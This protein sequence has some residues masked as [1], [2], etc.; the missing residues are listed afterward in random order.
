MLEKV[1]KG[2]SEWRRL[3]TPEQYRVTREKGTER[4]S[5][6]RFHD[7]NGT[8]VYLCVCCGSRLFSSREKYAAPGKWPAFWAPIAPRNVRAR[9]EVFHFMIR[10]EVLCSRCDAHL[11][12]LFSD[13]Q[14]PSRDRYV[15]NSAALS[16]KEN[17]LRAKRPEADMHFPPVLSPAYSGVY[18][19]V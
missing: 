1:I 14:S 12:Y 5:S 10:N 4:A 15:I 19:P 6:G 3:L 9:R 7:F 11:G 18:G 16:F 8:G 2:E 13:G 17:C